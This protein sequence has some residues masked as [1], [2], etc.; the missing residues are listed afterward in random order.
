MKTHFVITLSVL[1]A[2]TVF[3]GACQPQPAPITGANRDAVLTYSEGMTDNLLQGLNSSDYAAFSRDFDDAMKQ[4]IPAS[5]FAN[6]RSQIVDK[7]GQYVSRQVADVSELQGNI[8]VNYA[9]EF[10]QEG[11]VSVRVVFT[12]AEPHK[13]TGLWFNSPKL[14]GK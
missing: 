4:G 6:T 10:E 5:G 2:L 8:I 9:A 14:A 13:I 7:I 12:K 3:L 1:L 11:G